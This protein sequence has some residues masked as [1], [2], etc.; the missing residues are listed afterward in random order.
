M[1][2][3]IPIIA[4]AISAAGQLGGAYLSKTKQPKLEQLS[5]QTPAQKELEELIMSGIKSGTGP[6][7]GLLEG[8]NPQA[9]EE[10][11]AKPSIQN[12]KENILPMLQEKFIAGNQVGGSGAAKSIGRAGQGLQST[13]AN[14]LYQAQESGKQSKNANLM[15]LLDLI[16]GG[17]GP[18]NVYKPGQEGLGPTFAKGAANMGNKVIDY[19][20]NKLSEGATDGNAGQNVPGMQAAQQ[21]IAG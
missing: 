6:L 2:I 10:G 13:L 20:L 19:Y 16:A 8:F 7:S 12:F 5:T 11:V 3:P 9:F 17:R 21:A 15:Q 18:E 1:P 4:A 14:L